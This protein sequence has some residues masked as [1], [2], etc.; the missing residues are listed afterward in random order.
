MI[1]K[2]LRKFGLINNSSKS[3]L[4][5]NADKENYGCKQISFVQLLYVYEFNF[6]PKS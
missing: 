3:D 5:N 1:W 4:L 6:V 2:D